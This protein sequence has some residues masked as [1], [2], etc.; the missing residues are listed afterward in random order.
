MNQNIAKSRRKYGGEQFKGIFPQNPADKTQMFPFYFLLSLSVGEVRG[1]LP[2]LIS[3]YLSRAPAWDN[4]G[5]QQGAG[6]SRGRD[7]E[8]YE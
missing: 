6:G 7:L 1:L 5:D 2:T 8:N 3:G 4:T